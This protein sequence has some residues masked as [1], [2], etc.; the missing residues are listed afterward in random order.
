MTF[1]G[2]VSV[3]LHAAIGEFSEII[4]VIKTE[5]P[6]Y[7]AD[8]KQQYNAKQDY[9]RAVILSS[10]YTR[11]SIAFNDTLVDVVFATAEWRIDAIDFFEPKRADLVWLD[12]EL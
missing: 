7:V 2:A 1:F 12:L 6:K 10:D 3:N 8:Q 9:I 5:K 11:W 4:I